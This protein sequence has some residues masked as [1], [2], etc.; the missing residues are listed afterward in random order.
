MKKILRLAVVIF[1]ISSGVA[2]AGLSGTEW[3][4]DI[5][6]FCQGYYDGNVYTKDL[7][8]SF[9]EAGLFYYLELD[10]GFIVWT[11]PIYLIM[12][13]FVIS[14]GNYSNSLEELEYVG[15][16]L[17]IFIP[18]WGGRSLE[19]ESTGWSPPSA[20]INPDNMISEPLGA[21]ENLLAD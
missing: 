19:L 16:G 18:T 6:G 11:N 13:T 1:F 9:Y 17:I 15:F 21:F 20:R 2:F 8:D 4:D 14:F 7:D 3:C 10:Q 12:G 5:D